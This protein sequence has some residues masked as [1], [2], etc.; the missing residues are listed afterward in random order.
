[1]RKKTVSL[2][3]AICMLFT[4][5]FGALPDNAFA[6]SD[7]K[8]LGIDN[9]EGKLYFGNTV[10]VTTPALYRLVAKSSE[11]VTLFY[12]GETLQNKK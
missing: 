1:M 6:V 7:K 10:S 4:I 2:L 12:D 8:D 5:V 9:F 3:L 11:D